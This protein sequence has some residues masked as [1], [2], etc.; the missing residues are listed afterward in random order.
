MET[1]F[2]F[3]CHNWTDDAVDE[4]LLYK[5]FYYSGNSK[6]TFLLYHGPKST[7]E[8]LKLPGAPPEYKNLFNLSIQVED[9]FK[10]YSSTLF[11]ITVCNYL[12]IYIFL[13]DYVSTKITSLL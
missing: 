9:A 13:Y 8:N 12:D 2:K 4:L 10:A 7:V 3:S 11:P 1:D 5:V 6:E